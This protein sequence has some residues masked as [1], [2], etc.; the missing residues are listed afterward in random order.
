M[1]N[2]GAKTKKTHYLEVFF[3]LLPQKERLMTSFVLSEIFPS[4]IGDASP[5]FRWRDI[6]ISTLFDS[7]FRSSRMGPEV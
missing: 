5:C 7:V 3:F 6:S 1:L 2:L 4:P